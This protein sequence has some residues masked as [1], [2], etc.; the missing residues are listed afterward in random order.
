MPASILRLRVYSNSSIEEEAFPQRF[1]GV[2]WKNAGVLFD[3]CLSQ[4]LTAY[5]LET[6]LLFTPHRKC[7]LDIIGLIFYILIVGVIHI[8]QL[9]FP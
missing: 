5:M 2:S 7:T 4:I 1:A 8:F 3:C 6:S 9:L